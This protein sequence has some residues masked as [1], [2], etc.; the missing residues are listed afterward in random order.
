MRA[1]RCRVSTAE[2]I[3]PLA[4][5]G[6]SFMLRLCNW[7]ALA[8]CL[9]AVANMPSRAADTP[10]ADV[11]VT[12]AKIYTVDKYHSIAEALAVRDGKIVFVGSAADAGKWSARAR[13]SRS[14]PGA[15]FFR[16]SSM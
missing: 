3:G 16:G 10:A 13:R 11:V 8:G 5:D 12:D 9:A 15:S 1:C 2:S 7:V 6:R 14:S 4:A